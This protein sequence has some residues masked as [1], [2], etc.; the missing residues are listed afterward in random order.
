M[1]RGYMIYIYIDIDIDIL[2]NLS[3]GNVWFLIVG[4]PGINHNPSS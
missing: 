4:T 2:R 1:R 3:S